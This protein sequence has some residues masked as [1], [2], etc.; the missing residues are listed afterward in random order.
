L[1]AAGPPERVAE[2]SGPGW[3]PC[4]RDAESRSGVTGRAGGRDTGPPPE[5]AKGKGE[6]GDDLDSWARGWAVTFPRWSDPQWREINYGLGY[7]LKE[8]KEEN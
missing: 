4:G 2:V 1:G 5:I 7:H 6:D 8:E 3:E